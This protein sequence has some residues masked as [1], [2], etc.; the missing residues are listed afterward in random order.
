MAV[1]ALGDVQGCHDALI[2]LLDRLAFDPARD[3]LWLTGDLVNRGPQ[4]LETLRTLKSLGP[5]V[6]CV[7]GNHDL[8]L[9]AVAE[10]GASLKRLDTLSAVLEAPDRE[11]LLFWLRHRPL[12]HQGFGFYLIH[13]GLPPQWTAEEAVERAREVE[14]T[15]QGPDYRHWLRHM[16]GDLPDRWQPSLEGLDRLRFITNCLT[17]L[18]FCTAG[19]ALR[20]TEKGAPGSCS[21]LIPWFEHPARKSREAR[22]LFG[23]WSTLGLHKAHNTICLDTGCLWGGSLTAMRVDGDPTFCSVENP[24]GVSHRPE[25]S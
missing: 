22:I 12:I 3:E 25:S 20:L 17:R 6:R 15:L 13:A 2:R 1:Y 10:G 4:S 11:D 19:G 18:R 23:H 16:Y 14:R 8:H 21:H 9:L 24:P 5:A 7:L